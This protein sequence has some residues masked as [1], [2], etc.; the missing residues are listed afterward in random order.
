VLTQVVTETPAP[1]PAPATA[2]PSPRAPARPGRGGLAT[3]GL[4]GGLVPSP[5]AL[6][7]LLGAVALDRAWFGVLLVV[8]FGLGMA[9][10]LAL[11]GL[12]ATDLL[13]RLERFLVRRG[14]LAGPV[15]SFIA[16]GA[17]LGVCVIGVGVVVRALGGLA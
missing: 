1:A 5:S 14:R 17:A 10:T 12:L 15:R 3:I 8:S 7:L 9:V 2:Q 4:V 16:Y 11:V 6:V 13:G